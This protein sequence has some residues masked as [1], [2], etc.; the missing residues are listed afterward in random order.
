[1]AQVS[2]NNSRYVNSFSAPAYGSKN[3]EL[4]LILE[5]DFVRS[6]TITVEA[7]DLAQDKQTDLNPEGRD[8]DPAI[9]VKS[10]NGSM[11][12]CYDYSADHGSEEVLNTDDRN[13]AHRFEPKKGKYYVDLWSY[14]Q[15][16]KQFQIIIS[17]EE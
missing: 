7:I 2:M 12:T 4:T 14:Y 1:M 13:V 10:S 15:P 5:K 3:A 16:A 9:I 11:S 17:E 6:I 8:A